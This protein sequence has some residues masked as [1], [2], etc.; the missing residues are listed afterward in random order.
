MGILIK[1]KYEVYVCKNESE[2]LYI[3]QGKIGRHKH[4][5]SGTSHNKELN[6]YYFLNGGKM[7]VDIVATQLNKTESLEM[8]A[9]LIK[10]MK[11]RFNVVGVNQKIYSVHKRLFKTNYI[12]FE[13]LMKFYGNYSC[14]FSD[15]AEKSK[16]EIEYSIYINYTIA[17]QMEK[18]GD[19]DRLHILIGDKGFIKSPFFVFVDGVWKCN[20][21]AKDCFGVGAELIKEYFL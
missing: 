13:E 8:E 18:N 12:P 6:R 1:M 17:D 19:I 21:A 14:Y 4:C 3:G 10:D 9:K 11:P 7:F 20:V 2:V 5:T 16:N 15:I